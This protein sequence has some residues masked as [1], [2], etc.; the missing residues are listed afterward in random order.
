[1]LSASRQRQLPANSDGIS[2]HDTCLVMRNFNAS[3]VDDSS[4]TEETRDGAGRNGERLL[5]P[6]LASGL[7]VGKTLCTHKKY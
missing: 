4:G 1:M 3:V 7:L 2:K 6:G 5:Q